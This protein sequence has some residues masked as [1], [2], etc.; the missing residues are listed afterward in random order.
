M[1]MQRSL[2][3][4]SKETPE[5]KAKRERYLKENTFEIPRQ[6]IRT[7]TT[8]GLPL[9]TDS[10][11]HAKSKYTKVTGRLVRL[12]PVSIYL[13]MRD[14]KEQAMGRGILTKADKAIV[15]RLEK[16]AREN[17]ASPEK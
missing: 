1:H 6:P 11:Q 14:G 15:D 10:G 16:Q 12:D 13:K 5:Q 4:Q 3:E 2:L 17:K 8:G 7:W 9:T